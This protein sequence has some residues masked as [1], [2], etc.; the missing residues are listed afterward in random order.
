MDILYEDKDI[1]VLVKPTGV[2]SQADEK[3]RKSLVDMIN[4]YLREKGDD[5]GVYVIHRLDRQV[6]GVMVYAKTKFAASFLCESIRKNEMI[7][8]YVAV[9]HSKPE[10]ESGYMEDLLFKDSGKNKTYIVKRERH[11]VKKAKLYY[12]TVKTA[13][14]QYGEASLVKIRLFTG[15]THQIRVQFASRKMPLIGDKKYGGGDEREIALWSY[16]LTFV[17]PVTKE[18]MTFSAENRFDD[19]FSYSEGLC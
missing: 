11:G 14:T 19:I 7:K 5:G 15:R 10:T 2:L 4:E 16:R 9:V 6:G 1:I 18:K 13:K 3:G 8:E 12:E 17:H